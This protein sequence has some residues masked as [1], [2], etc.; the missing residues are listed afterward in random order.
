MDEVEELWKFEE[1]MKIERIMKLQEKYRLITQRV[2]NPNANPY[3]GSR[4]ILYSFRWSK[5]TKRSS[6]S[7]KIQRSQETWTS[8]FKKVERFTMNFHPNKRRSSDFQ[9]K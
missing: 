5:F 1:I 6:S 8:P 3:T 9:E 2:L 4:K 7:H